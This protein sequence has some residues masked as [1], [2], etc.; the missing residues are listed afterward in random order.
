[1]INY[2][3]DA[4]IT[5]QTRI[6]LPCECARVRGR[7]YFVPIAQLHAKRRTKSMNRPCNK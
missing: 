2:L 3:L 1:M 7:N 5:Q 4:L 6:I